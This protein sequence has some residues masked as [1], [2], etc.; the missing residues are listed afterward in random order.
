MERPAAAAAGWI[1]E[2]VGL[3]APQVCLSC[4]AR[5]GAPLCSSCMEKLPFLD[6]LLC[7]VCG[8]P[9]PA[10]VR[11]DPHC[12]MCRKWAC[13]FDKNRSIFLYEEPLAAVVRRFKFHKRDDLSRWL[14]LFMTEYLERNPEFRAEAAAADCV[15]PVPMHWRRLLSR[16]YNQ[17]ALLAAPVGKALDRPVI[18]VLRRTDARPPQSRLRTVQERRRNI[19]GAFSVHGRFHPE[20][21]TILLVDDIIT[22]GSTLDE[23]ARVLKNNGAAKVICFTLSKRGFR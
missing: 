1:R 3:I 18:P 4:G 5:R 9:L 14:A 12:T 16:R 20:G 8:G 7:E 13:R 23:C 22:T 17:V 21:K 2:A 6:G 19:V 10:G 15:A 11:L